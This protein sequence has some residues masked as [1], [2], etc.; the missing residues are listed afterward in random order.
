MNELWGCDDER[1][2]SD[3]GL[4]S[5]LPSYC[6]ISSSLSM[7]FWKWPIE[8]FSQRPGAS[9]EY[10]QGNMP[11][12]LRFG[13]THAYLDV[14]GSLIGYRCVRKLLETWLRLFPSHFF[15]AP[16]VLG[17][18]KFFLS[19]YLS[20]TLEKP[21]WRPSCHWLKSIFFIIRENF[22]IWVLQ[23]WFL[24]CERILKVLS[25]SA[26]SGFQDHCLA[27]KFSFGCQKLL[28]LC[29]LT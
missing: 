3:W 8:G 6:Q 19:T 29:L 10:T 15:P 27:A 17:G 12:A 9:F 21:A 24:I 16:T 23:P 1:G 4:V 2:Y 13:A 18:L 25:L 5:R 26:K 20:S 7:P 14:S 22:K 28:S 11:R